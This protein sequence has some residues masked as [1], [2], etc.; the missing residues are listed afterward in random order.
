[1]KICLDNIIFSLQHVGGVSVV[2]YELLKRV[3]NDP[4]LDAAFI[5]EPNRNLLRNELKIPLE[6]IIKN[7]L[8]QYPL[9]VQR[10]LNPNPIHGN[11]IFH[12]SYYRTVNNPKIVNITTVHDFTYE[13]F[14]KGIPK[15]IHHW[16]KRNAICKSKKI[17]C[18][19]QNTKE[20]LLKFFPEI[21]ESQ[22]S[23]IYNGVNEGFHPLNHEADSLM[24]KSVSFPY[25]RYALYIGDRK[26]L[27]KNFRIAVLA[28]EMADIPLVMVGGGPFTKIERTFLGNHLRSGYFK[29]FESLSNQELNVVYNHA[30][31]LL[32]PSLY[33]GFGLPIIEAQKAGCPVICS[34]GSSI[35]EVAGKGALIIEK[36]TEGCISDLLKHIRENSSQTNTLRNEGFANADRFSWDQCYQQTKQVYKKIY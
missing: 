25:G 31:C 21:K 35:P 30:L 3:L 6:R 34:N 20:D 10:Y 5:D 14:R 27:Y 4:E 29:K 7:P 28:C 33:E 26:A 8:N 16:Q 19:S 18:V 2:W 11:G 9:S 13:F 22:I 1:M 17:I 36:I 24:I 23:V 15:I 32:Y 12:S